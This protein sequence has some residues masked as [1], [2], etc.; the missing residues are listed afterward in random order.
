MGKQVEYGVFMPVGEGGWIRSTTAPRVPATYTYN[1]QVALLAEQLGLDFLLAMAKWRGFGGAS[2]HWDT[3]LESMTVMAGLAEVTTRLRLIPTV[4][5][6]AFNVALVA[7]MI[8]TLDQIAQGRVGLNIVSGW[9]REELGQMGLWPADVSHAERYAVAR[10][11]V[12]AL[13]RLWQEARVTC[14]GR[15]IHLEDCMSSPKPVQTPHPPI[16]CA[17]NS[18]TGLRFTVE[19][20]QAAFINAPTHVEAAATSQR[21][22]TLAAELGK[23]VK[24]Y[25]MVMIIPGETDAA[26]LARMEHYNLGVDMIALQAGVS[27]H[28]DEIQ[29]AQNQGTTVSPT[30]QRRIERVQVPDPYIPGYPYVGNAASIAQQL[31]AV[32]AAGDFDGFVLTFPDFIADLRFFGERVLPLLAAAGFATPLARVA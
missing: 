22:K 28:Q 3:T 11:W 2:Q 9:Y 19:E 15:Y 24:T 16:V 4:H 12:Q 29:R 30:L 18:D 23:P 32:I 7:K 10:E 26:A 20:A 17:G 8:A 27:G 13:K 5:T 21:A 14:H 6:L 31:Q 25:A 1:R